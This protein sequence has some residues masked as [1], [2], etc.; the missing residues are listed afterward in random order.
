[1]SE[2]FIAGSR[3]YPLAGSIEREE[4]VFGYRSMRR[5]ICPVCGLRSQYRR[6]DPGEAVNRR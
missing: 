1:M 4:S 6:V 2:E 3:L 5:L